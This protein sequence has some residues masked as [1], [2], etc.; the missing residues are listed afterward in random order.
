MSSLSVIPFVVGQFIARSPLSLN[1]DFA[2][3]SDK[4]SEKK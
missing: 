3:F 4:I 2:D 1:C